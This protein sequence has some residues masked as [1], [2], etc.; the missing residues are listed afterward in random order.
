VNKQKRKDVSTSWVQLNLPRADFLARFHS[1]KNAWE[2][3]R[4]EDALKPTRALLGLTVTKRWIRN[5]HTLPNTKLI[6]NMHA[7]WHIYNLRNMGPLTAS[8]RSSK[9]RFWNKTY[10][11]LE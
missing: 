8:K 3:E 6:V 9:N 4:L 1:Q 10:L 7:Q 11:L 5:T 2:A